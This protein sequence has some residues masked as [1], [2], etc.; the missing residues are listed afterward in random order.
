MPKFHCTRCSYCCTLRVKL[1]FI[2]YLRIFL[3]G[4]RRFTIKNAAGQRCIKQREN[5]DCIFL[6][7]NP[8]RCKI[9]KIRP[10]MCREYP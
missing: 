3:A 6:D 10:K 5:K 8:I 9:Y 2:D 1:S 7:R 4:Y